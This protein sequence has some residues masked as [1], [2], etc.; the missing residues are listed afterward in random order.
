MSRSYKKPYANWVC[1]FS[2]KKDKR[3]ANQRFRSRN[4]HILKKIKE[5]LDY[6][7]SYVYEPWDYDT[8]DNTQGRLIHRVRECSDVWDFASDG[9][10]HYVGNSRLALSQDPADKELFR[11]WIQK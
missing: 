11:K 9:L 5:L 3:I 8:L 7:S 6:D 10:A 2:N 4:K 1:Y